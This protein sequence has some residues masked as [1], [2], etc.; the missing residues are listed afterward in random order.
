MGVLLG[1]FAGSLVYT[2]ILAFLPMINPNIVFYVMVVICI[3]V[4]IVFLKLLQTFLNILITSV[5]GAYMAVRVKYYN[6]VY[7]GCFNILT[8]VP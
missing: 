6:K 2:L 7:I 3:A 5:I 4:S 8:W 1:F